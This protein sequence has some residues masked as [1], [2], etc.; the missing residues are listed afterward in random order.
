[1]KVKLSLYT[2]QKHRSGVDILLH[3]LLISAL[4]GDE[5][6]VSCPGSLTHGIK[7]YYTLNKRLGE[8]RKKFGRF[9]EEINL[10][11]L[12]RVESLIIHP[13]TPPLY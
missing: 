1:M 11:P 9:R 8:I 5:Q 3:R 4:N 10:V 13:I 2:P 6:P 12:L 7:P